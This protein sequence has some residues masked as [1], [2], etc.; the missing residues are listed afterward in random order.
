M[1]TI[2]LSIFLIL[3]IYAKAF[4]AVVEIVASPISAKIY[5][6]NEFRGV[7]KYTL[8]I[9]SARDIEI[10]VELDG[11]K[12][13]SAYY[14]YQPEGKPNVKPY[15]RKTTFAYFDLVKDGNSSNSSGLNGVEALSKLETLKKEGLLNTDETAILKDGILQNKSQSLSIINELS[16]V[17]RFVNTSFIT[18]DDYFSIKNKV[19]NGN[20]DYNNSASI[21]LTE[22]KAKADSGNYSKEDID[23]LKRG[24]LNSFK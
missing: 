24:I 3:S 15:T 5:V 20:Y 1:K 22:L 17:R 14:G 8:H 6:N 2:I 18:K 21:K 19:I 16:E 12:T 9:Y 23:S 10:K 11:Y 4:H 7:G 13:Q